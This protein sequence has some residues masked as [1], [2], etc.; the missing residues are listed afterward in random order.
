MPCQNNRKTLQHK[1]PPMTT[2]QSKPTNKVGAPRRFPGG[3]P[4]KY[5]TN[6]AGRA[7]MRERFDG[8][9]E[10]TIE[11]S[12]AL[13]VPPRVIRE[14]AK[15]MRIAP[16]A[17]CKWSPKEIRYLEKHIG[18]KTFEEIADHL[19]R[20]RSAVRIKAHEMGLLKDRHGYTLKDVCEG[21][22]VSFDVANRWIK[23]GWLKGSRRD[24]AGFW[25]FK[26][27]D[28]RAFIISHPYE[29]NPEKVDLLWLIDI[30]ANDTGIGTLGGYIMSEGEEEEDDADAQ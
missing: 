1:E 9:R 16:Q 10:R 27:K 4:Q 13:G 3:V 14:W 22:G 6:K 12:E 23:S 15:N 18:S 2:R 21:L 11:L 28:I 19:D 5:V 17:N 20:S 26:D 7:L 24:T 29:L 8:S 30:V 25:D